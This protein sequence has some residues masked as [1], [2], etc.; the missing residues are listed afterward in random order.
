MKNVAI[1][2][3]FLTNF[4]TLAGVKIWWFGI[5]FVTLLCIKNLLSAPK[6]MNKE[7][8]EGMKPDDKNN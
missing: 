3:V 7:G 1:S 5:F 2:L 8:Y 6:K 4:C